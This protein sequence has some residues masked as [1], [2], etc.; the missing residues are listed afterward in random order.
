MDERE[1]LPWSARAEVVGPLTGGTINEVVEVRLAGTRA[2]A[3]RSARAPASLEWEL[4]L[5]AHLRANGF[6]VPVPVPTA[7][8][9]RRVGR[10]AVF[11]WMDG[12]EP[13]SGADWAAVGAE[14]RRLHAVTAGWPQRPGF[15]S[16]ADLVTEARGGPV[17]LTGMPA[18]LVADLRAAWAALAAAAGPPACVVHGDPGRTNVRMAG[19]RVGLLDWDESRVDVADLDLAELPG[20]RLVPPER[21]VVAA[22]A[23]DAWEAAIAWPDHPDYVAHRAARLR[24]KLARL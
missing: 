6:T 18:E 15:R 7:D 9:R 14:L 24:E 3:R 23:A 16:S 17:D 21:E 1:L 11:R 10:L 12:D 22:A 5:L 4:D 13:A 19:G 20:C 2:V 8:G